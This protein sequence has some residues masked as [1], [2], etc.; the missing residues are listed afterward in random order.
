MLKLTPN[1][2]FKV[3]VEIQ[4][5]GEEAEEVSFIFKH[6][7][8]EQIDAFYKRLNSGAKP[9]TSKQRLKKDTDVL[10]E[11]VDGWEGVDE[12]FSKA[13]LTKLISNYQGSARYILQAWEKEINQAP[14]KN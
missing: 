1:P 6:M 14:A 3:P 4:V 9:T 5:H 8:D 13:N 12:D 10:C 7:N 11:I 2:T